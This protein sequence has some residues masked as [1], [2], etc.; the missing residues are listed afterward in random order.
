MGKS[1]AR[2]LSTLADLLVLPDGARASL[3]NGDIVHHAEPSWEH[4]SPLVASASLIRS[5]FHR[6]QRPNRPGGWWITT[7]TLIAFDSDALCPD[8][9]GWRRERVPQRPSGFPV[10]V[11]PDWICEVTVSTRRK[12]SVDVPRILHAAG[13]GWYWRLDVPDE[14][15]LVFEWTD[16][17]YVLKHSFFREDTSVRIPPFEAIEINIGVLLGDDPPEEGG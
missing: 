9:S 4:E 2:R 10:Q 6:P 13:V 11:C 15:L 12:D 14:N 1:S 3:I 16:K 7:N 8:I 17:G 5:Q